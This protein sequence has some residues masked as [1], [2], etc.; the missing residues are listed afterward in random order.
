MTGLQGSQVS[1]SQTLI[2]LDR[3]LKA[4]QPVYVTLR[5][6]Y[7]AAPSHANTTSTAFR[8]LSLHGPAPHVPPGPFSF[9]CNGRL[10]VA[11]LPL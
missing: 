9:C 6:A 5:Q 10:Q 8:R 2:Q 1:Y 7:N 3:M 11:V 4:K